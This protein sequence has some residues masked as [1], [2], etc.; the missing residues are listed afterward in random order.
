[1]VYGSDCDCRRLASMINHADD[2]D[3][4]YMGI[5]VVIGEGLVGCTG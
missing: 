1:M 2:S 4:V 5:V 3:V